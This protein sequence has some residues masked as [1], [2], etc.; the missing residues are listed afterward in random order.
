M[1]RNK[2]F[3]PESCFSTA[4]KM[5]TNPPFSLNTGSAQ[6]A[7]PP[8]KTDHAKVADV[9]RMACR[10]GARARSGCPEPV[11]TRAGKLAKGRGGG[12][13]AGGGGAGRRPGRGAGGV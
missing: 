6:L 7:R 4:L 2:P 11:S 9:T 5:V 10:E 8:T 13:G 1:S 12:G 3:L